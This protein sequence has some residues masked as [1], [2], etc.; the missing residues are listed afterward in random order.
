MLAMRT[1]QHTR[2]L[3]LLARAEGP[4]ARAGERMNRSTV[5]ALTSRCLT[6]AGRV[7]EGLAAAERALALAFTGDVMSQALGASGKGLAMAYLGDAEGALRYARHGVERVASTEFRYIT[8][9][10]RRDLALVYAR[11][12]R[13]DDARCEL[14]KARDIYATNLAVAAAASVD[15]ELATLG[16]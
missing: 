4:L 7:E 5:F 2:A 8:A 9:E 12:G 10:A 13:V 11:L 6:R 16:A 14:L 1:G 3:A 15:R